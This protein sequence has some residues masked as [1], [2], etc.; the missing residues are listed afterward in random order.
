MTEHGGSDPNVPGWGPP[1]QP[2]PSWG[3]EQQQPSWGA[4]PPGYGGGY[5]PP[6]GY[7]GGGYGYYGA[8]QTDGKAIGAL[9]CA[10]SSF[11]VCPFVTAIVAL[12]LASQSSRDIR[13]SGG[14]LTGEGMNTAARVI[15]WINIALT[16]IAVLF[17]IAAAASVDT[18]GPSY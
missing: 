12:I 13:N 7:G 16:V 3:G 10:I 4:P 17:F 15:S 9:I 5:G 1:Q 14:R 6:Q 11:V 8:P 18:S 2:Q